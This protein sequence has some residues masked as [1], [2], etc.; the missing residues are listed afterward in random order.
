MWVDS[1]YKEDEA[2]LVPNQTNTTAQGKTPVQER[3]LNVTRCATLG[4]AFRR[5]SSVEEVYSHRDSES[6]Q[7][8]EGSALG[9]PGL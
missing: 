3:G 9:V 5:R 1:H 6:H 8:L 2:Q 7:M 4:V